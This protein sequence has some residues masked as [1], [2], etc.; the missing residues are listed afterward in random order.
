MRTLATL[1]L[2]T[3][4]S[5][6]TA[7][8]QVVTFEPS[9]ATDGDSLQ[10]TFDATQGNGELANFTG[11]VYLHTGVITDQSGDDSDWRYVQ[12]GWEDRDEKLR[13]TSLG[14]NKWRFTYKPTIREFFTVP[15][16]E[17]IERVAML[18][19][20]FEGSTISAVGRGENGD[21]IFIDIFESGV[22]VQFR[23]P[24]N[25]LIFL[26]QN[27]TY[28]IEGIGSIQGDGGGTIAL[29][30]EIDG[31]EVASV[32]DDTLTYDFTPSSADRYE[33][34]L[35]GD[36]G[37][38][39]V[40]RDTA[41]AVVNPAVSDVDRPVGLE[42]GITYSQDGT[43]VTLSLFAPYKEF[44]YVIGDFN[45]WEVQPEYLM[46]RDSVNADSV[47]WWLNISGLTP[48]TEYGFQ[49]LV[50][51]QI[52][53]TDP[54]VEKILDGDDQFISSDTYPNL[55]PYPAGKTE[56]QVG[57][58]QPGKTPYAWTVEN[59]EKPN[60]DQMVVYELL[61]RDF[62][63]K[64]DYQ[65]MIDTL[66]YLER[67]GV[68]AIELMPVGEFEGN[69]S[70]G[71][72]PSFHLAVD[73]YYG[74][75][76]DLKRFIDACHQR[77]IAVI[78]DMVLNHAFGQSPLVRLY[79]DGNYGPPTLQNPWLNREARHPFNV[80]Y[81]FNHE[82]EATKY[83]VDRVNRY[84]LEEFKFDGF[85]FDLS[86]GFTQ[87]FTTDVG[88]WSQRDNSRIQLL[89]RMVDK[90]WEVDPDA[91][92][93]M[94]HFGA[95]SEELELA[96]YRVSEGR[97]GMLFW[98]GFTRPYNQLSMGYWNSNDFG[99]SLDA[100]YFGNTSWTLPNQIKYMESHDE[101]WLMFRNIAYGASSST[102]DYNVRDLNV[103]LN[104]QKLI[105]AFFFTIPG[106]KMMWQFGELGYG[107]GDNG[108]ECL[109]AEGDSECP[110]IAP[111]RTAEKPIRWD[112]YSDPLRL[113]L[114]K[115]WAALINA[116]NKYGIFSD[117]ATNVQ[118]RIGEDLKVRWM[119]LSN[120]TLDVIVIG[121]FD[122]DSS[123]VTI[124]VEDGQPNT[125]FDFFSG[126]EESFADNTVTRDYGPG[127][128]HIYS[129]Q[130]LDTPEEGILT[131]IDESVLETPEN[132]A[133]YQ[134]YPNPFNPTTNI[135][136]S[137]SETANVTL[138]V[139]D[140]LGRKVATLIN[141]QRRA[142]GEYVQTFDASRLSSGV[143]VIYLEAGSRKSMRKMTLI[144]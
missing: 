48:G 80:G 113:N 13:A 67:L 117:P 61:I 29:S 58:L 82:S 19:R 62:I 31:T 83:F 75:A 23:T 64:H 1:I 88:A 123:A 100:V 33:L 79:N 78:L 116:R 43:T 90:L 41:Y 18:F 42:D 114:Y 16:G 85:R 27:Q 63:E 106:P 68:N 134:N 9:F 25:D 59:F 36:N 45:N 81:D 104:R 137:L 136:F 51:G 97:D 4:F 37:Q 102:L 30:L 73:K 96:N 86:K 17:K 21:D 87:N 127:E 5:I 132:F 139:Y 105:G 50:D 103:A 135:P 124:P 109:E 144:K 72:N 93:I 121:N 84:W 60:P 77:G 12:S 108:E 7:L 11:D 95:E 129:T 140:L 112:Y 57:V 94:E 91:Y 40:A 98:Q 49:Y 118:T 28:T 34:V 76:D 89:K 38:G 111:G 138:Q 35:I 53:V 115:T 125:W 26:D 15:D 2:L 44:V 133:L 32:A 141:G 119:K 55:K 107:Y 8:G 20:G 10:V 131:D 56:F 71:Y 70:W 24:P 99:N 14:D 128:F 69:S 39:D 47:Y 142:A 6:S 74:P 130:K 52:R 66:G 3:L 65:T 46:Q 101:Q 120:D 22:N 126:N 54:Y 110:T 92:A 143:Y 122:V